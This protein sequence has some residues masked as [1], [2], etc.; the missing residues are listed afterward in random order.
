M[1]CEGEHLSGIILMKAYLPETFETKGRQGPARGKMPV[2][3]R[4]CRDK[5]EKFQINQRRKNTSKITNGLDLGFCF[6]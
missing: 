4:N 2:C 1:V 5:N 6:G 3:W